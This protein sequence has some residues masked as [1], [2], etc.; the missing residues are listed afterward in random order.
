MSKIEELDLKA[1]QE[2]G[3]KGVKAGIEARQRIRD[4]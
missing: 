3:E 2:A 1:Y 4:G